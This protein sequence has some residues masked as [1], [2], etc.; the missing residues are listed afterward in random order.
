M[1]LS[2]TSATVHIT[3]VVLKTLIKHYNR[4]LSKLGRGNKEDE[5]IDNVLYDEAFHIVKAF[6][7]LATKNTIE[8][9]QAF[10][11]THAPAP[12]G[13]AVIPIR[14]PLSS[15]NSAAD[16]LVDW[17]GPED[18]AKV[19]GGERWWQVR[20]IDGV[21][22]E[23]ITEKKYLSHDGKGGSSNEEKIK[24]M[25]K[26]EP[27][28][29]YVHGG[30]FF[31][32][33][34]NTHR[35]H[36]VRYARKFK[37]KAFAVS[38]RKAPQYPW[39]CPLHDVLAA[40][41]YLTQPPPGAPHTAVDP[42]RLVFAGDSAGGNLCL[43][44]LTVLRD[45]G[46][47]LPAGAV[48]ISPW[49]DLTHSFESVMRDGSTDIIPPYG[50]VHRPSPAWPVDPLPQARA[51]IIPT[52][53]DAPPE[54]GLADI[55]L[56]SFDRVGEDEGRDKDRQEQGREKGE[57]L[58]PGDKSGVLMEAPIETG[59]FNARRPVDE[60]RKPGVEEDDDRL[61]P[62]PPKVRMKD[63]D[64]PPQEILAQI[65]Q[66]AMNEQLTHP[67][68]SPILQ[69]SLGNLCPLFILAGDGEVL[70]D[71]IVYIAHRAAHPADYPVRKG[72]ISEGRRQAENVN[73]F[74]TPTKVHLQVYDGMPHV[75]T[76]FGFTDCATHAYRAIAQFVRHVTIHPPEYVERNPFPE[77]HRHECQIHFK[78][79]SKHE[80]AEREKKAKALSRR[81]CS[82][83]AQAE[84]VKGDEGGETPVN[85]VVDDATLQGM[86]PTSGEKPTSQG[87]TSDNRLIP[88]IRERVDV[89]GRVRPMERE[90]D[91]AAL[92]VR[93]TDI[94]IMKEDPAR[95]WVTGQELTD[96]KFARAAVK[97][98]AHRRRLAAHAEKLLAEARSQG[99][100]VERD[101]PEQQQGPG[102]GAAEKVGVS[103]GDSAVKKDGRSPEKM[104]WGPLDLE[105]E[106]PPPTAIAG[107]RDT[108]EA[109]A[110]LKRS[111]YFSAPA[112]HKTIPKLKRSQ[113]LRAAFDPDDQ[114]LKEPLPTAAEQQIEKPTAAVHGLSTWNSLVV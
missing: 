106:R 81:S 20:G 54:P 29:L 34:I 58:T 46:L 97:V 90:A 26:L 19:V 99:L 31:W 39:P 107:R 13:A 111:I 11:N 88:M 71:E 79:V 12:F 53:R 17:F 70:I 28:M 41:F 43:S 25:D 32:G 8:S 63:P 72:I 87:E 23:W 102:G 65:Q 94:G 15:C 113:R 98:M 73:K 2:T 6:N 56:Q 40:Y 55:V 30:G 67:L 103:R 93:P 57:L 110:L 109:L 50:F 68:V 51:R 44:A 77:A 27:V 60:D 89:A 85:P 42:K 66:Y 10:T 84:G 47:P 112:T 18:L 76:V 83:L 95:R 52:A 69:G 92:H 82:N 3:P 49:V 7:E 62:K 35:H 86:A 38:Y 1:T 9:L 96:K 64:A 22:A 61:E 101:A 80:L 114:A 36:I 59:T 37:G 14:I 33:S 5:A 104:R 75:L 105:N 108:P 74:T 4:K 21:D 24:S 100:M 78:D 16:L 91:I 45:M 48:L